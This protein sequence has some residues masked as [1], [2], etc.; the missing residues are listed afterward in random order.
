MCLVNIR[1]NLATDY[2]AVT[3][4]F[5]FVQEFS[6][7]CQPRYS[8]KISKNTWKSLSPHVD[9]NF[10]QAAKLDAQQ[11]HLMRWKITLLHLQ[12]NFL[13]CSY[14]EN[15]SVSAS[16]IA[17]ITKHHSNVTFQEPAIFG[18]LN[19]VGGVNDIPCSIFT[20]WLGGKF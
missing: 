7:G 18:D 14:T 17:V 5:L 3:R 19:I 1:K 13:R 6:A 4:F 12:P 20:I 8:V 16:I 10:I 11:K 9:Y 15:I 2:V